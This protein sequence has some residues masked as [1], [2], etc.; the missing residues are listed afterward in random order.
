MSISKSKSFT[1]LNKEIGFPH[2][3]GSLTSHKQYYTLFNLFWPYQKLIFWCHL[4]VCIIFVWYY[5]E[6]LVIIHLYCINMAA[7]LSACHVLSSSFLLFF[8]L[9]SSSFSLFMRPCIKPGS[10]AVCA[11]GD[12]C[13]S[14]L[15][16]SI[17]GW[18]GKWKALCS[19]SPLFLSS[20]VLTFS[21]YLSLSLSPPPEPHTESARAVRPRPG[22][23]SRLSRGPR[24]RTGR[25]SPS[26]HHSQSKCHLLLT[27]KT[28]TIAPLGAAIR[29]SGGKEY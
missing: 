17:I 19:R 6:S 3:L 25:G 11:V 2:S 8:N 27:C 5:T 20:C 26:P 10:L 18:G 24:P 21:L 23:I 16:C 1:H 7:E 13:V 14:V 22:R 15:F 9:C 29:S 12:S 4:H 28:L